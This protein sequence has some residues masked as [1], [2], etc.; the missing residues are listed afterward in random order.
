[1]W[2]WWRK[3]HS[4]ISYQELQINWTSHTNQP[5]QAMQTRHIYHI[6]YISIWGNGIFVITMITRILGWMEETLEILGEISRLSKETQPTITLSSSSWS[7]LVTMFAVNH[8]MEWL[9]QLTSKRI[10]YVFCNGWTLL[11]LLAVIWWFWVLQME[12]SFI[13]IWEDLCTL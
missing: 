11:F 6:Q 10:F 9:N 13:N 5:I 8:L 2:Q 4:K 12:I 1:M 7:S 3:E